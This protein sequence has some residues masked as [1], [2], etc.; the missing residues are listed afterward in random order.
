MSDKTPPAAAPTK[1]INT[2]LSIR[3]GR[4]YI[5]ECDASDLA[6]QFGTPMFVVSADHVLANLNRIQQAFTQRWSC[7]PV[8]ILCAFKAA[9]LLAL[10]RLLSEAGSGCDVFGPGELEGAIR[11][12]VQPELISVNG[13][14]KDRAMIR[15]AIEIGARIVLDSPREAQLC[16]EEAISL[17][18]RARVM[19]RV[20][21]FLTD[22]EL[23]SDFLPSMEIRELTQVIK[24]GIPTSE[25][26]PLADRI[27]QSDNLELIG[28]HAHMGRHSK[29]PDVW[30]AWTYHCVELIAQIETQFP[31]WAPQIIDLGGGFPSE[32]DRDTDVAVQGYSGASLEEFASVIT[33][34]LETALREFGFNPEGITLELEPGRSLH[35]DTAIHLTTVR[36]CK[37]EELHRPR[38]WAEIDTSEVF[39]GIGGL[40]DE[41]PFDFIIANKA[42]QANEGLRDL[43]G[44]TCNAELLFNQV[45]TPPLA[46][47]D[48]VALLNTG[49]YI[50]PMA[51]N[52][53]SLPRPGTVL[54]QG[55]NADWAK[56]PERVEEVFARDLMPSFIASPKTGAI[57]ND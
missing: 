16:K 44:M 47:G 35:T 36:N 12:G 24:Y 1:R 10:R 46:S 34:T 26:L 45:A 37:M 29:F 39:L 14:I 28:V 53:N 56:R 31:G 49:A 20:K 52:F 25:L 17:G 41:P 11:G 50:E 51:A 30:Q 42:D 23:N 38:R 33:T 2:S 22:L 8:R 9:P 4:L 40:N 15:R 21:P 5:D 7:G 18:R 43:V 54:V 3:G 27:S 57:A 48:V 19:V 32:S 6:E 13:S 55:A